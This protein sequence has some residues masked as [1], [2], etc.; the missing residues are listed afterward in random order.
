M[1]QLLPS[2]Q[3]FVPHLVLAIPLVLVPLALAGCGVFGGEDEAQLGQPLGTHA[4]IPE[5]AEPTSGGSGGLDD[6]ATGLVV[7]SPAPSGSTSG[8]GSTVTT[9]STTSS[10]TTQGSDQTTTLAASTTAAP[11]TTPSSSVSSSGGGCR[12]SATICVGPGEQHTTLVAAVAAAGT[13]AIIELTPGRYNETVAVTADNVTIRSSPGGRS[14]IDCSGLRPAKGKACILAVGTNLTVE[15]MVVTGARGPDN[16]EACF[17]N[18]P[19][20]RFTVR[21]VECFGSNNGILGS[22]GSWLIED[23]NFHDNGAGDGFS[24]NLYLSGE[25]SEVIFRRSTSER[26]QGGHA[27]KSRCRTSIIEGSTL[28]DNT[29][30]DA[31]EFS[32][33][34][35]VTIRNTTIYQP[36]GPNG[37]IVRHGA[38]G[39]RHSGSLTF[40]N[41]TIS[42][43]RSQSYLRS[44]CQAIVL[45][46]TDLPS[47]VNVSQP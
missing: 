36:D 34:G 9:A 43:D 14:T 23:S 46:G 12:S 15:N 1:R 5:N 19:G 21:Q 10:P 32:Y 18:E 31:A 30:A 40:V 35:A 24:H 2:I 44:E 17:R 33:G 47:G 26:A 13:G 7:T 39:C 37:N 11:T 6:D 4:P 22:G 41:A 45:D 28:R 38:E 20:T 25:C 8:S 29:V 27:F 42:S 3:A 16:N